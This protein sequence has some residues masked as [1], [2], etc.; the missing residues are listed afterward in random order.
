MGGYAATQSGDQATTG[1]QTVTIPASG[2]YTLTLYIYATNGITIPG[3]F[4][5]ATG[6]IKD[7]D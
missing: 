6:T 2:A 3:Y 7:D 5:Y 4:L 1:T